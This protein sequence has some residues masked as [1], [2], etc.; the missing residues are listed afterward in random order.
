ML[1]R[2]IVNKEQLTKLIYDLQAISLETTGTKLFVAVD[3]EGGLVSRVPFVE[4]TGQSDLKDYDHAFRV[5]IQ[6]AE[7][8][9]ELGVNMNLAPVLD[10][11]KPGDFLFSRSFQK[12]YAKSLEIAEGFILGQQEGGVVAVPKHF[13]G[14]DNVSFNPEEDEIPSVLSV[15][16]VTLFQSIF[17]TVSLP[18][19]MASHVIYED[20]DSAQA[21]PFSLRGIQF[22]REALGADIAIM[23]DDILSRAFLKHFSYEDI[24]AQSMQSG[25]DVLILAG[26]PDAKV[27]E[28]FYDVF[29]KKMEDPEFSSLVLDSEEKI[30]R[31][32]QEML[33]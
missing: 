15:P 14:Y 16:D 24:A 7:A 13:P 29:A 9:R 11:R 20:M 30:I 32:K 33:E 28:E 3:Q 27:V 18:F 2:N 25:V 8:L 6:R 17:H 21:F 1:E 22:A 31:I 12:S 10:S 5:G 19:V 4:R 26:Y 23:S